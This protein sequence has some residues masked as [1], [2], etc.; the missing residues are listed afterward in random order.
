MAS[1]WQAAMKISV[2]NGRNLIMVPLNTGL[3]RGNYLKQVTL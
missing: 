1:D 3:N 2:I